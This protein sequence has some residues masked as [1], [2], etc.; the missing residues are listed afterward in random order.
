MIQMWDAA[1]AAQDERIAAHLDRGEGRAAF[2]K[3]HALLDDAWAACDQALKP[4]GIAC[5]NVGDA[6]RTVAGQFQL[7]PNHARVLRAFL[8]LGYT[9]L[10]DILWR[11]PTNA[12]NKFMGSGMLPGG[13][14]VTYEHEYVLI[15]RKG[16]RR[17]FA[18]PQAG[19]QRRQSAY[20][21]E[22]RNAWFSDLWLD[23]KGAPQELAAAA[24]R[25]RSAAFPFELAYRLICMHSIRGDSVLDPFAGT[26]TTLAAALAAGRT[27]T[28]VE[29]DASLAAVC[30]RQLAQAPVW[31]NGY[32]RERL[33]RHMC[34]VA[35]RRRTV[36]APRYTNR[37]YGFP[38]VTAQEQ[39]LLIPDVLGMEAIDAS[40][41][42][43]EYDG[44]PQ[45]DMIAL[46]RDL[47]PGLADDARGSAPGLSAARS[48]PRRS[49]RPDAPG[50]QQELPLPPA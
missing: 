16:P 25:A 20:F 13:A 32:T 23:L 28:G 12:P 14:Y 35:A 9:P 4:G 48:R 49:P 7:F 10:P 33:R 31:A 50:G 15:L 8:D 3:M 22:E 38:V 27:A 24:D 5:I 30:R 21:W 29:L 18:G 44:G 46:W 40:T 17:Q 6:T 34:F 37:P 42:V 43:V 45:A 47:G 2:E 11:K 39:D 41:S 26:G 1:F 19:L 36:G